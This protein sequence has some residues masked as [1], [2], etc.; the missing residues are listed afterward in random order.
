MLE[1]TQVSQVSGSNAVG[2]S[3]SATVDDEVVPGLF[4]SCDGMLSSTCNHREKAE[5][6]YQ[7]PPCEKRRSAVRGTFDPNLL[8]FKFTTSARIS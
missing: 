8:P 2:P 6:N 4:I 7:P 1:A 5:S 3:A